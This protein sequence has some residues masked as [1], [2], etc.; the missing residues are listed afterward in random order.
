[1]TIPVSL[2]LKNLEQLSKIKDSKPK[3]KKT[4]Q[5]VSHFK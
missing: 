5:E 1:M 3:E 4:S 2:Y